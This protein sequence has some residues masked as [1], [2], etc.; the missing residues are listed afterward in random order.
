M[1]TFAG[2]TP[3]PGSDEARADL[4]PM[5][6]VVFLILVFFLC[7]LR[8][9]DLEGQLQ[10]SLPK[11]VGGGAQALLPC[12]LELSIR[13]LEPGERRD[14]LRPER[15][16]A[17]RGPFEFVGRRLSYAIGPRRMADLD[18]VRRQLGSLRAQDPDYRLS[19]DP[20]PGAVHGDVLPVL[21]A[22]IEA[23]FTKVS[24]GAIP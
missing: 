16:W 9:R 2:S 17:G 7:T 18:A 21:D 10:A 22:A 24:F 15:P 8:F 19:L 23:G 4:T 5:I 13:V 12:P 3:A 20:G 11:D 1:K 6:D 14:A